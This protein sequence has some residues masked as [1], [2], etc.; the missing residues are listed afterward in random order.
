MNTKIFRYV[1]WSS[2]FIC[3]SQINAAP[4]NESTE[5]W[6]TYIYTNINLEMQL[7]PWKVDVDDQGRRWSLFAYPLVENPTADS[8]YRITISVIKLTEKQHIRIYPKTSTNS[9]EWMNLQHLQTSQM[10]NDFLIYARRDV[11]GS[12]GF[13]YFCTA[14]I[15][16]IPNTESNIIY[17]TSGG[18]GK[19][20]ADVLRI[21][22]SVKVVATNTTSNS[23][24]SNN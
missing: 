17:T 16:K 1:L 2:F 12:N 21:L 9:S 3:C 4:L 19:L 10:T 11:F 15:K 22:D 18:D 6:P 14:R 13:A 8:Q 5:Q 7:P 20:T 24:S 23:S